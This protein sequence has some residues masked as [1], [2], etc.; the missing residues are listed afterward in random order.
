VLRE[1]LGRPTVSLL[2]LY[3]DAKQSEDRR[4]KEKKAVVSQ[5]QV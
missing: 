3:T 1:E 4:V 5:K 2:L